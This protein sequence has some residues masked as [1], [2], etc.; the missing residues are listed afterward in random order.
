VE[1]MPLFKTN[2]WKDEGG[3][4]IDLDLQ[5]NFPYAFTFERP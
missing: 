3:K 1:V 5:S 4:E 2:G